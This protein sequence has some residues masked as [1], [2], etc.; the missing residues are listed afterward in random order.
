MLGL[1]VES[2]IVQANVVNHTGASGWKRLASPAVF[3]GDVRSGQACL[4]ADDFIG[5]GGTIANLRGHLEAGG[6]T[7]V[8][9][10]TL[11]GKSYSAKLALDPATL[12]ALRKRH[13]R[14]L[15]E[16]WTEAFGYGFDR[17]TESEARYLLRA[18]NAHAVRNRILEAGSQAEH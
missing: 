6:A 5:Q 3:A 17:L 8:G 14:E 15:E 4:I 7:V 10:V 1:E 13:G 12:A 2:G 11:T 9:A 16:W 18:E